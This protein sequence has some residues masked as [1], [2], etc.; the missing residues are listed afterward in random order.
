M[1]KKVKIQS[2]LMYIY[3]AVVLG[4]N[5]N[6][7]PRHDTKFKRW[8]KTIGSAEGKSL[9]NNLCMAWIKTEKYKRM[10]KWQDEGRGEMLWKPMEKDLFS[11]NIVPA[12][13]QRKCIVVQSLSIDFFVVC[14][15]GVFLGILY[16]GSFAIWIFCYWV[17]CYIRL[18][19]SGKLWIKIFFVWSVREK[20]YQ[21]NRMYLN[22]RIES[23]Y[24]SLS[25]EYPFS[26]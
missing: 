26:N 9:R 24:D 25:W 2:S 21:N 6:S 8:V 4:K 18:C 3:C 15:S 13:N 5:W 19:K 22:T 16:F 10:G 7:F 20:I 1:L 11:M 23:Y 17:F 14:N 12:L